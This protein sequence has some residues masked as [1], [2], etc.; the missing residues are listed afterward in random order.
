MIDGHESL[1]ATAQDYFADSQHIY[2]HS[3]GAPQCAFSV[4]P[5]T[6][7]SL[8]VVA[9]AKLAVRLNSDI[10]SYSATQPE[11]HVALE[12]RQIR[13]GESVPPVKMGPIPSWRS[14][15]VAMAPDDVAFKAAAQWQIV[16]PKDFLS[17]VSNVF[18]TV[19]Y[20]GD[21]GRLSVNRHLID[22]D[23]Y[24][25]LPWSIGLKRFAELIRQAPLELSILPLRK[26]APIY[27]E[28]RFRPDFGSQSQRVQL[29][30]VSAVPEYE[31]VFTT[32]RN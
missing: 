27:L 4:Y 24:N 26:D 23:F 28:S 8:D 7:H 2:L 18:L 32:G 9:P 14:N 3:E 1:V 13:E 22:D 6:D 12:V 15:G 11:K 29:K 20:T 10:S 31:F 17:G 30:K 16:F 25:G 5:A 19:E 21:V